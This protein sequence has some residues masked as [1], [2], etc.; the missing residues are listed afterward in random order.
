M[1]QD[2]K[3]ELIKFI[4]SKKLLILSTVDK[5]G[6]PW[7]CNVYFSVDKDFNLFFV[8]SP[9]SN[10]SKHIKDNPHVSFSIAW[11]DEEDLGNRKGV[12]GTG[13]CKR[14]TNASEIIKLLKNHYKYFP[15]W[16]DTVNHKAMRDKIIESRPYVIRPKYM[17]FWDDELFD[18]EKTKEFNF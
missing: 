17:K 15:S 8:S 12:Q 2:N 18:E 9:N 3:K 16:R 6:R 11:H 5:K 4:K 7:T 1:V 14:V 10:H 13:T